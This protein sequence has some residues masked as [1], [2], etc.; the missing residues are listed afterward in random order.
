VKFIS[1]DAL[2]DAVLFK[3]FIHA[4]KTDKR[5]NKEEIA[6]IFKIEVSPKRTELALENLVSRQFVSTYLSNGNS[7]ITGEGYRAVEEQLK[8]SNSF[9][10][11]YAD[12]GDEW[13]SNQTL[14]RSDVPASDR[15]VSRS[16]NEPVIDEIVEGL[17]KISS[18]LS[19]NNE[20]GAVLGDDKQVISSEVEA[21]QVLIKANRFHLSKLFSL[22]VPALRFLGEKF[23]GSAIGETAKRLINLIFGL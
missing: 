14:S 2:N 1:Q 10:S 6:K 23:S 3:L 8:K 21:S 11:M 20:I 18:E 19:V 22:L 13:L 5:L 15:L 12:N 9:I 4:Q 16:D 17:E 7:A